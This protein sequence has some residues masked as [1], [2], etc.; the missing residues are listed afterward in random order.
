MP[1]TLYQ[2]AV[3]DTPQNTMLCNYN[4]CNFYDEEPVIGEPFDR[5]LTHDEVDYFQKQLVDVN[6]VSGSKFGDGLLVSVVSDKEVKEAFDVYVADCKAHDTKPHLYDR[7]TAH[8]ARLTSPRRR[9]IEPERAFG[10]AM[11]R[12]KFSVEQ[13]Y[14]DF[15]TFLDRRADPVMLES[16]SFWGSPE[17]RS[18]K[19][20]Y[21]S[22]ANAIRGEGH[23]TIMFW[24]FAPYLYAALTQMRHL[25]PDLSVLA[26]A[27]WPFI[28]RGLFV[29]DLLEE[30][31]NS[32][33]GLEMWRSYPVFLSD[34]PNG[35]SHEFAR[36]EAV[37][38]ADR[39]LAN[40]YTFG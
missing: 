37:P 18:L 27:S 29:F 26:I 1:L 39:L 16:E 6:M 20:I 28:Q 14:N 35:P 19:F 22:G 4:R 7:V 13:R 2:A 10:I 33:F 30:H 36:T 24:T 25:P 8:L 31:G 9:Q 21:D 11:L 3:A 5:A 40:I 38:L 34:D 12:N 23:G 17:F 15:G 32:L